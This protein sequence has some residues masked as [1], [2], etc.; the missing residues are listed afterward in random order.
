[1][2]R[3]GPAP[4]P[5]RFTNGECLRRTRHYARG[6]PRAGGQPTPPSVRPRLV[7]SHPNQQPRTPPASQ[8]VRLHFPRRPLKTCRKWRRPRYLIQRKWPTRWNQSRLPRYWRWLIPCL[9]RIIPY[10]RRR[11]RLLTWTRGRSLSYPRP[12]CLPLRPSRFSKSRYPNP[13][14]RVP[15]KYP[16][17]SL[18][19]PPNRRTAPPPAWPR[20]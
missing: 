11:Q 10:P 18:D 3:P 2:A 12:T 9:S 4:L 17:R 13:R 8:R 15:P 20:T 5:P 14:L 6:R 7:G 19:P 1:M 16:V